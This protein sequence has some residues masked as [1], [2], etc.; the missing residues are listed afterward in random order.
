MPC[1]IKALFSCLKRVD[2]G[3]QVSM[4]KNFVLH[5]EGSGFAEPAKWALMIYALMFASAAFARQPSSGS[6]AGLDGQWYHDGRATRILVAPDNRS[7]TIINEHGQRSDGYAT[8]NRDLIIPSLGI[9]GRVNQN[10]RRISWTNGTEWTRESKGSRPLPTFSLGGPWIHN[11]K[12]AKIEVTNGGRN[13]TII[14]E[15]GKRSNGFI[16]A[17]GELKV[18]WLELTGYL[19]DNGQRISWSNGTEWT[20]PR[21]F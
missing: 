7:I 20:R 19:K 8:S 5:L 11:G 13:F 12:P 15:G 9:S 21:V 4:K 2:Q 17:Q 1:S 10:G 6:A 18:P 16:N 14:N 3:K